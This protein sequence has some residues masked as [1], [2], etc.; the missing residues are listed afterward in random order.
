MKRSVLQV[1]VLTLLL[2]AVGQAQAGVITFEGHPNDGSLVQFQD[3]FTFSFNAS[4]WG[5][6]AD[7]F[8]GGGAPYTH[9]GT[10]RLV[11]SGDR[12]NSKAFVDISATDG[13]LFTF[14][15]FDAA[16]MFPG[17]TGGIDVIGQ[18]SGGGTVM[19]S[20][21]L[22][23]QFAT[24][25]LPSTFINLTSVRVIDQFSGAFRQEPGFS[26]DN[27]VVNESVTA[28]PE[29]T[30]LALLGLGALGT[31]GYGWRRRKST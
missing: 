18:V 4:G 17:F 20:F 12:S 26:L 5:I 19:A 3:G 30:S 10:T 9:N 25:V 24:F 7:S 21:S 16:T 31:V 2:G 27:L 11:A 15:G 29:P 28:V 13:S 8:V 6:F 1:A 14:N 23:D 22:T